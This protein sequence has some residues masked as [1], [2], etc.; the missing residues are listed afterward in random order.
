MIEMSRLGPVK[1]L[2]S[3]SSMGIAGHKG[4]LLN[5]GV[6]RCE[7]L[8]IQY[9]PNSGACGQQG[10]GCG[11]STHGARSFLSPPIS[12]HQPETRVLSSSWQRL[13]SRAQSSGCCS[14]LWGHGTWP[15]VLLHHSLGSERCCSANLGHVPLTFRGP[16]QR[17][18][19]VEVGG[20][21]CSPVLVS[22]QLS[23]AVLTH[24]PTH[25]TAHNDSARK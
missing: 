4:S 9:H 17:G 16:I 3:G 2:G 15:D 8:Q 19:S 12:G 23:V 6:W 20:G 1:P 11:L 5:T 10:R 18:L 13:L 25:S 7:A 22:L 21:Q 14:N 24:P